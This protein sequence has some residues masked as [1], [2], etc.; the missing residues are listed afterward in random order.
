MEWISIDDKYPDEI[1]WY[2][3]KTDDG[4]EAEAP[5]IRTMGQSKIFLL[6]ETS[7]ITH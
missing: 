1:G 5:Y 2:E 4:K 3:I 7:I 6:P